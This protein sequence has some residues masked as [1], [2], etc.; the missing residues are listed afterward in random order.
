M[1]RLFLSLLKTLLFP[2]LAPNVA[3][4]K[5]MLSGLYF[6]SSHNVQPGATAEKFLCYSGVLEFLSFRLIYYN[7]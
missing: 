5:I 3:A 1:S 6:S 2:K 4:G 7:F